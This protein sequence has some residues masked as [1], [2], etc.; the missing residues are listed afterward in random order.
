MPSNLYSAYETDKDLES[1]TGIWLDFGEGI[2]R[3]LIYRAG[4]AN[5]R[6]HNFMRSHILKKHGRAI[7]ANTIGEEKA[8][9]LW[10]EVYAKTVVIKW[11]GVKD[12]DGQDIPYSEERCVQLFMD[13]PELF[14][15]IQRE[16]DNFANFKKAELDADAEAL[17]NN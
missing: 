6:Y 9:R 17:K 16:A 7:N 8:R 15:T 13:L 1:G 5:Q 14:N 3:F 12:R 4:G 11:E 2:G 10:A